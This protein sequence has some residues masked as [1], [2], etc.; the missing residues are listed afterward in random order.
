MLQTA[1][2]PSPGGGR[3]SANSGDH[4]CVAEEA[5]ALVWETRC[6]LCTQAHGAL[7]HTEPTLALC[8][9]STDTSYFMNCPKQAI[10][11]QVVHSDK[12]S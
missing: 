11:S 2:L 9:L 8:I 7:R 5:A 12:A 4:V 10:L 1:L 3:I 6:V